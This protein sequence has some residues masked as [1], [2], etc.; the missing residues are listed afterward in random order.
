MQIGCLDLDH[1]GQSYKHNTKL[2]IKCKLYKHKNKIC[3]KSRGWVDPPHDKVVPPL[4]APV[5][6]I[7]GNNLSF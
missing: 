6:A 3:Q 7:I 4:E 5:S 1:E 2:S